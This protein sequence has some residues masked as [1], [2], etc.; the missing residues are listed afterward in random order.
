VQRPTQKDNKNKNERKPMIKLC[1]SL[2]LGAF[3]V[4]GLD[5][6]GVIS[7]DKFETVEKPVQAS[8]MKSEGQQTSSRFTDRIVEKRKT[9]GGHI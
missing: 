5:D 7:S 4:Y 6:L 1:T 2:I 9:Q 8:H 3:L